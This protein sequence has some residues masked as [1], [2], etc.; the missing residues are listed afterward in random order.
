MIADQLRDILDRNE[1]TQLEL[2]RLIVSNPR[3]VRRWVLWETA[4]PETVAIILNLLDEQKITI[5]D[6]VKAKNKTKTRGIQYST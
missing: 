6:I 2:A 4:I 3:T 1:L 5:K